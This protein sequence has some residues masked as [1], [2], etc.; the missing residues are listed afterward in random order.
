MDLR[1]NVPGATARRIACLI[2]AICLAGQLVSCQSQLVHV[3]GKTS[4]LDS[5]EL[6]VLPEGSA[7]RSASA[8]MQHLFSVD[9]EL[10]SANSFWGDEQL[11][12]SQP[13]LSWSIVGLQ[14]DE[15]PAISLDISGT[16]DGVY[17]AVSDYG[18]GRWRYIGSKLTENALIAL[19][20]GDFTNASGSIFFVLLAP[21]AASGL[22][23]TT[24][25]FGIPTDDTTPPAWT[26][27]QGIIS[28][29]ASHYFVKL[30]WHEAVDSQSPPV[31]YLIYQALSTDGI[32]WDT[33]QYVVP[34]EFLSTSIGVPEENFNPFDYAVRARDASGNVTTN[35]NFISAAFSERFDNPVFDWDSGDKLV[36][37]WQDP[38]ED[39]RLLLIGPGFREAW[40]EEPEGLAGMVQFSTD[41]LVSGLA[42]ESAT[43]LEGAIEG[44]YLLEL[45]T[46][47]LPQ[48]Y[49]FRLY[50]SQ[51]QLKKDLGNVSTDWNGLGDILYLRNGKGSWPQSMDWQAG[52]RLQ[53]D[54]ADSSQDVNLWVEAPS[55]AFG[56]PLF[57][58]DL[59]DQLD[60]SE[61]SLA[62]GVPSEWIRLTELADPGVYHFIVDWNAG[63]S[64]SPNSL[65]VNWSV[66]DGDDLPV[67]GPGSFTL[68]N[69]LDGDEY[70]DEIYEFAWLYL[71]N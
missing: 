21:E 2:P 42:L 18:S 16:L 4:H 65:L 64:S 17:V 19:P 25:N 33:P 54:W 56:G 22:I 62:S 15:E 39:S 8:L 68:T 6:P 11:N 61:E 57:P 30:S 23:T 59:A 32:D 5:V 52:W 67:Y 24:L 45:H 49:T 50:D 53:L 66:F 3:M 63:P 34:G 44:G 1:L 36:V 40:P 38:A 55:Y 31:E 35:T 41:S 48:T 71:E 9:D 29:D 12:L 10:A 26:G 7:P 43:L 13:F 60:F 51:G 27:G 69:D 47:D 14:I 70:L 58:D 28:V 37:G 46:T 20:D